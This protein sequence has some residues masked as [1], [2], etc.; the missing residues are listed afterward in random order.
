[1]ST[2]WRFV[3]SSRT[4]II[5]AAAALTGFCVAMIVALQFTGRSESDI[6]PVATMIIG[7]ASPTLVALVTLVRM[8]ETKAQLSDVQNKVNGHLTDLARKAGIPTSGP[9]T[10]GGANGTDSIV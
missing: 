4:I 1:M 10:T 7:L 9:T 3:L 8:E 5:T 6:A 2:C